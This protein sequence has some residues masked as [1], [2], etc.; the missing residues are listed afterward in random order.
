MKYYLFLFIFAL[1][2]LQQFSYNDAQIKD[3]KGGSMFVTK[4]MGF[5]KRRDLNE[6]GEAGRK[7][8]RKH[9]MNLGVP[10]T[11]KAMPPVLC[12]PGVGGSQLEASCGPNSTTPWY[13]SKDPEWA[14][15]WL[16]LSELVP[17]PPV[18]CFSARVRLQFDNVTGLF[19]NETDIQIRVPFRNSTLGFEYLD[20]YEKS[21]TIYFAD[22]VASLEEVGYVQGKNLMGAPYDWRLAPRSN[23]IFLQGFKDMIEELYENNQNTSVVVIAH[24]MGTRYFHDFLTYGNWVDQAWKDK[25]IAGFIAVAPPWTGAVEAVEAI[26]TGYNFGIPFFLPSDAM[27]LQRSLEANYYLF[28]TAP[29]WSNVTIISTGTANFTA[30]NYTNLFKILGMGESAEVLNNIIQSS[31]TIFDPPMVNTYVLHGSNVPTHDGLYFKGGD[32][33]KYPVVL[34]GM[35]TFFI[36]DTF[37]LLDLFPFQYTNEFIWLDFCCF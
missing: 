4:D 10:K 8:A 15:I 36:V 23:S 28:P 9:M 31:S 18:N 21:E 27:Y 19:S 5:G 22:L 1:T 11:S 26:T 34:E 32:F 24:S 37:L 2:L 16:I 6:L 25:Y 30:N 17:G 7:F 13:C 12:I 35:A 3:Y 14:L 29:S 33:T 20:P